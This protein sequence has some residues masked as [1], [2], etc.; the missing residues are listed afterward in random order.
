M[1]RAFFFLFPALL[2]CASP[3]FAS[4]L[5]TLNAKIQQIQ[6]SIENQMEKIKA[7]REKSDLEMSV[8]RARIAEQLARSQENLTLQIETLQQ[9]R[10]QIAE[11][12]S[13]TEEAIVVF[14][15]SVQTALA[16]ALTNVDAQ[17][18]QTKDL[19]REITSVKDRMGDGTC[20]GSDCGR[21]TEP[22]VSTI[23]TSSP[24][25]PETNYPVTTSPT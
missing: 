9:L 2:L 10:E 23:P 16:A 25:A 21:S 19:L 1:K 13:E 20:E 18:R 4:N 7:T 6:E 11:K 3:S 22:G 8:A 17:I 12:I 14:K 24:P 15:D 5:E